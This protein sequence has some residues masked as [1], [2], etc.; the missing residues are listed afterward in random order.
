MK[1]K[2]I[3][4]ATL[5]L[6]FE[7]QDSVA[8]RSNSFFAQSQSNAENDRWVQFNINLRTPWFGNTYGVIPFHY[9]RIDYVE[10]FGILCKINRRLGDTAKTACN[11]INNADPQ[12]ANAVISL[13]LEEIR[14][15]ADGLFIE[16]LQN[17]I[18]EE[19]PKFAGQSIVFNMFKHNLL[20]IKQ[21]VD[22]NARIVAGENAEDIGN[23]LQ[24]LGSV[25]IV[26]PEQY[27]ERDLSLQPEQQD[28][29]AALMIPWRLVDNTFIISSNFCSNNLID[30][31]MK[32]NQYLRENINFI[33][34]ILSN[35]DSENEVQGE[36]S[37]QYLLSITESAINHL[38]GCFSNFEIPSDDCSVLDVIQGQ[39][40]LFRSTIFTLLGFSYCEVFEGK[41]VK[42]YNKMQHALIR[43]SR[44]FYKFMRTIDLFEDN[45]YLLHLL[46]E[47]GN[48][49]A[50]VE[51]VFK[52]E[53]ASPDELK[54]AL[55]KILKFAAS[56]R[57]A[58]RH[59]GL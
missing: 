50:E 34:R 17:R 3:A 49:L 57:V 14:V 44:F 15:D 33:S 20:E 4:L 26:V 1:N 31:L 53:N 18:D 22:L 40:N 52:N 11:Y 6:S 27:F 55:D 7:N 23:A 24:S 8:M 46:D 35:I 54:D 32:I 30:Q 42:D 10:K 51:S 29:S 12:S 48:H 45:L 13:L 37:Q 25:E 9:N 59:A 38:I 39:I 41:N 2:F 36:N 58:E 43:S 21:L 28:I 16:R 56:S 47:A 19:E 5:L